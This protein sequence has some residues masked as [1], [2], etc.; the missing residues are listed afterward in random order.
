MTALTS[1]V[2]LIIAA[3]AAPA[4][5]PPPPVVQTV[6]PTARK[7]DVWE[8]SE[9]ACDNGEN[10]SGDTIHRVQPTRYLAFG[11]GSEAVDYT[12]VLGREARALSITRSPEDE[13]LGRANDFAPAIAGSVFPAFEDETKCR[14]TF[15]K[16]A[17]PLDEASMEDLVLFRVSGRPASVP[18]EV[19]DK[20]FPG[21]CR[22]SPSRRPLNIAYPDFRTIEKT[23]G[24]PDWVIYRYGSDAQGRPTNIEIVDS[25][26]SSELNEAGVD[27]L[28][29]SQWTGGARTGCLHYYWAASDV[30]QAS[31]PPEQE[32]FGDAPIACDLPGR[33]E[34]EPRLTYPNNFQRRGIEG[35]AVLRFDV[36]PWG[37]I[38]NVEVLD[39][40]PA[41]EFGD[42]ASK[43]LD[44]AKFRPMGNGLT[45]CIDR[46]FFRLPAQS[47]EAA[48]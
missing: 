11:R 8:A 9:I 17:I 36:A 32:S 28:T 22:A 33:W 7:L 27:A 24:A 45:G 16:T 39:A 41:T 35:W 25:S 2:L 20:H 1:S 38:G 12:F 4:V 15:T 48:E 5:P 23:P 40:Q 30:V 31:E 26:G 46:V 34:L 43:I 29:R 14:V 19:W 42:A 6:R 18:K 21:D 10:L 44:N 3:Q 37:E 47:D 13:P